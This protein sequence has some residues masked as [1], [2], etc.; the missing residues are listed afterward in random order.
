MPFS[1]WL[2]MAMSAPT[3]I[4]S[5]VHRRT[6]V[7]A[8]LLL[9]FLT[10]Y[11]VLGIIY[12]IVRGL[13]FLLRGLISIFEKDLKKMVALSTLSQISLCMF[14]VLR[15]FY[16]ASLFQMRGH[17]LFKSLLFIQVGLLIYVGLGSQESRLAK[18]LQLFRRAQLI[19]CGISL[20][21]LMYLSGFF[22]KDCAVLSMRAPRTMLLAHVI[23]LVSTVITFFYTLIL[24]NSLFLRGQLSLFQRLNR[25]LP[26]LVCS[27]II[28]FGVCFSTSNQLGLSPYAES[29]ILLF[30]ILFFMGF[31]LHEMNWIGKVYCVVLNNLLKM[32]NK[33]KN[34]Q[35]LRLCL[36][37]GFLG[38]FL[39]I[40]KTSSLLKKFLIIFP[41]PLF[42]F[43]FF[44]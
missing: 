32:L 11:L 15:G 25:M 27:L 22:R 10:Q 26:V 30:F 24:I 18:K 6:L 35:F 40:R 1:P 29:L 44:C 19:L 14:V 4:R 3:P 31:V 41:F 38:G 34:T 33:V 9:V 23:F 7:C 13:T 16:F 36:D 17:A 2:P 12:L 28:L 20:S 42:L 5:L 8:G 21:G 37:A 39:I 43:F